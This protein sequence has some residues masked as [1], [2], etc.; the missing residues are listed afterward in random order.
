[1]WVLF[2]FTHSATSCLLIGAF[3]A[4]TSKVIIDRYV[5]NGILLFPS[6]FF[7]FLSYSLALLPCDLMTFFSVM[8]AFLSLY[9]LCIYCQFLAHGYHEALM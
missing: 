4:F 8:L 6:Y 9:F 3:H 5:L 1:M 2:F 7:L